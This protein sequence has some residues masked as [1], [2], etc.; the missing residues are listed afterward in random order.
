MKVFISADMEGIS[1]V[2]SEEETFVG[3][4]LHASACVAMTRDVNAAV[5]GAQEAGAAQVVVNDCHYDGLNIDPEL[6]RAGARLIRGQPF[7][8]MSSGLDA[9]F[10]AVFLVGYHAMKGTHGAVLDHTFSS[11]F[12]QVRVNGGDIGE[13]GLS[14]AAAGS[15]G[16]PVALVTGDDKVAREAHAFVPRAATVV[17]KQALARTAADCSSAEEVRQQIR[18]QARVALGRLEE[19]Q[20]F[21][22]APPLRLEVE[23]VY[24][25]TADRAVNVPGV[26]RT[27]GRAIATTLSSVPEVIRMLSVLCAFL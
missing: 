9:S 21:V 8:I 27:G 12:V 4:P 19:M 15:F 26:E 13:L 10:D 22:M 14:A 23:F 16:V 1:G 11:Q 2:V 3:R 5:E 20:T 25:R 18:E 24:T 6:L 7:P 17:T